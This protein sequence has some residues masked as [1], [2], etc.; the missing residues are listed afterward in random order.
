M[1]RLIKFNLISIS[2][3]F[4]IGLVIYFMGLSDYQCKSDMLFTK[5]Y[6]DNHCKT[7]P[8]D[9]ENVINSYKLYGFFVMLMFSIIVGSIT[10]T[11][12]HVISSDKQQLAISS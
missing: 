8:Y 11:F 9:K 5:E 10:G 3:F 6:L 2:M 1:N 7:P 12:V 4:G